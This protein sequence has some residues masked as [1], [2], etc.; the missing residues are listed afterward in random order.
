MDILVIV[1]PWKHLFQKDRLA[2]PDL[3]EEVRSFG[4][5]LNMVC[6]IERKK[7]TQIVF[8]LTSK[9]EEGDQFGDMMDEIEVFPEDITLDKVGIKDI[10]K[11]GDVYFAGFH[12]GRCIHN[13]AKNSGI[14]EEQGLN[15]VI[16][17]SLLYPED[18]WVKKIKDHH[19]GNEKYNYFLWSQCLIERIEL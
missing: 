14:S 4:V 1:D 7:G 16:N 3:L 12:F 6:K 2:F 5:F 19:G 13:H 8:C 11:D 9:Y 17:L 10:N 15:I 18:S